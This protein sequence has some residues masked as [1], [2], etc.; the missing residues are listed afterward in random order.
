[1]G[2]GLERLAI[3]HANLLLDLFE[4]LLA[5]RHQSRTAPI[6]A[7]R[8][9]EAEAAAFHARDQP[10]QFRLGSFVI[11][12]QRRGVDAFGRRGSSIFRRGLRHE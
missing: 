4:L 11:L 1:M 12:G 6:S 10:F 9:L 2:S 5:K 3:E 8:L 7:E